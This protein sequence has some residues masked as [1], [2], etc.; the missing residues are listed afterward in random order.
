MTVVAAMPVAV[1]A[2]AATRGATIVDIR[3]REAFA[4]GHLP[5]SINLELG[6]AVSTYTKWVVPPGSR[7]ILVGPEPTS[8]NVAATAEAA[9]VLSRTGDGRQVIGRLLGGVPAWQAAGRPV[10]RY[11]L[12]RMRDLLDASVGRDGGERPR[13]LD[14]RA[15]SEWD[16]DGFLPGATGLFLADLP[17]RLDGLARD[18]EWWVVCAT[19]GR[20][21]VAASVLDA[22][23]VPVRLVGRGGVIGWVERFAA[24]T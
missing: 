20:A 3:D 15:P 5:G 12:A 23:D 17:A 8:A 19:G 10:R 14:V 2:D 11:A 13:V 7:I 9:D 6:E 21:A 16:E 4:E 22:A 1:V 18:Q 24:A